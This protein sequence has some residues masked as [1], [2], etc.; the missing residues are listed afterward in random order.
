[1]PANLKTMVTL[2]KAVQKLVE[3]ERTEARLLCAYLAADL[4]DTFTK[5]IK[6]RAAYERALKKVFDGDL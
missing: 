1:M 6:A 3:A 2:R 5:T 4:T